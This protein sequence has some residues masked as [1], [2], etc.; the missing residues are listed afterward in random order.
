MNAERVAAQL[1]A[2]EG[3]RLKPYRCTAGRLTIG[4]GRNLDDRGITEA[5][6]R[7]LLGNDIA[8]CWGSLL[9]ALPWLGNAP[10]PVQEALVNMGFNMGVG[11]LLAFKQTLGLV[12]ARDYAG[13]ARSMLASKWAGQVGKRAQRLAAQ[14]GGV[15]A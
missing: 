5:E 9:A 4:V 3:L 8:D 12:A 6:A 10:E 2:D 1:V 7:L 13:A 14:V 11:G 15:K